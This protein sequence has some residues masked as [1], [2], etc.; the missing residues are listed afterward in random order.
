[1]ST[2]DVELA[3]EMEAGAHTGL[4]A[5]DVES[6]Q[7]PAPGSSSDAHGEDLSCCAARRSRLWRTVIWSSYFN[8]FVCLPRMIILPG[9]FINIVRGPVYGFFLHPLWA[10]LYCAASLVLVLSKDDPLERVLMDPCGIFDLLEQRCG[11]VSTVL[12]VAQEAVTTT[13]KRAVVLNLIWTVIDWILTVLTFG[14]SLGFCLIV[15]T[16]TDGLV[17]SGFQGEYA[18][19]LV[20]VIFC[21]MSVAC[22]S[23]MITSMVMFLCTTI[24]PAPAERVRDIAPQTDKSPGGAALENDATGISEQLVQQEN[25][26]VNSEDLKLKDLGKSINSCAVYFVV[27]ILISTIILLSFCI[28]DSIRGKY[29]Q[30]ESS[31]EYESCDGLVPI[32]CA[33]PFPSSFWLEEDTGSATG[34]KVSVVFGISL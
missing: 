19:L 14:V 31:A 32:R 11:V 27:A 15:F 17:T 30:S 18:V 9:M 25:E 6:A 24:G 21:A 33:L 22:E 26:S 1:M 3:G 23:V 13:R 34:Y 20:G 29:Y 16:E 5:S 2:Q 12:L 4:A 8:L 7:C 28:H 10:M